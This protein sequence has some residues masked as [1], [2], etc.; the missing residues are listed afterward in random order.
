MLSKK[1]NMLIM[2]LFK[3]IKSQF[4]LNIVSITHHKDLKTVCVCVLDS[5]SPGEL[6]SPGLFPLYGLLQ[7]AGRRAFHSGLPQ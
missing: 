7:D 4:V 1:N 5:A 2:I 6:V 3:F